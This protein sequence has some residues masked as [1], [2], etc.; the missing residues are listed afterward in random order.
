MWVLLQEEGQATFLEAI[1]AG[2]G[3]ISEGGDPFTINNITIN[4]SYWV[5]RNR[6]ETGVSPRRAFRGVGYPMDLK[7]RTF[8][9]RACRP[10]GP[11]L[12]SC[13]RFGACSALLD[14][15]FRVRARRKGRV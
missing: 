6:Y 4:D 15:G 5:K 10:L 8:V 7:T 12:A 3:L 11:L 14:S 9:L 13:L 2:L 1:A